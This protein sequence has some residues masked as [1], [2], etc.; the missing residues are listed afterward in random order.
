MN[1]FLNN[2]HDEFFKLVFSRKDVVS[3]FLTSFLNLDINASSLSFIPLEK[4]TKYKKYYLDLAFKTK[5]KNTDTQIYLLFEHKSYPDKNVYFQILSYA[6][7]VWQ[8]EKENLTP[9]IPII[10]YHGKK[11]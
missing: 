11:F 8:E 4:N 6:L 7:S 3:E 2:P 1:R 10:F 5:Y 9:I